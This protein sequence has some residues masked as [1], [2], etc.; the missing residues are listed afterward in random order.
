MPIKK[1]FTKK[2]KNGNDKIIKIS[3]QIS[4]IDSFRF[5]S[6]SLSSL[7]SNLCKGLHSDKCT[8]FKSC[9]HC[10][11]TKDERLIFSCF[12]CKKNYKKKFNKELI[13]RFANRYEFCN[14]DINKFILLLSIGVY[15]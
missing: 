11:I 4:F 15:P 3:C 9:L 2:D 14:G 1:E 8:D 6:R 5:M 10:M 7:F 12:E 13:K